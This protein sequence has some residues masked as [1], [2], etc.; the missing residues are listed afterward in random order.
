MTIVF[1]IVSDKSMDT[2]QQ[3][4]DFIEAQITDPHMYQNTALVVRNV[5]KYIV[6]NLLNP[7]DDDIDLT[8][9]YTSAQI[10]QMIA[11][12][13]LN[14]GTVV[15]AS[16]INGNIR[17]NNVEMKVFTDTH[18]LHKQVGGLGNKFLADDNN[19]YEI[20]F[21]PIDPSGHTH[22]NFSALDKITDNGNGT[23]VLTD[24]GTYVELPTSS[25]TGSNGTGSG[26]TWVI[27]PKVAITN[28]VVSVTNTAPNLP[29]ADWNGTN[30][31]YATG[32]LPFTFT[33]PATGLVRA[34]ALVATP[35]GLWEIITGEEGTT[36]ATPQLVNN[37][38]LGAYLL[39][40]EV[41]GGT[42]VYP[43]DYV[44]HT[45][46][47]TVL[48]NYQLRNVI[49]YN[50]IPDGAAITADYN[51]S[52][53][54]R[55]TVAAV[56][57]VS[58]VN[59]PDGAD[60]R[61]KFYNPNGK[62]LTL[63]GSGHTNA[64]GEAITAITLGT[65]TV[66]TFLVNNVSGSLE[67]SEIAE[68]GA[69][70][71]KYELYPFIPSFAYEAEDTFLDGDILYKFTTGHAANTYANQAAV[72]TANYYLAGNLDG[73]L[74]LINSQASLSTGTASFA[75]NSQNHR[76][77]LNP[78][79]PAGQ[80]MTISL[81]G[82]I[83]QSRRMLLEIKANGL[84]TI[85]PV[86]SRVTGDMS[87][88]EGITANQIAVYELYAYAEESFTLVRKY[89]QGQEATGGLGNNIVRSTAGDY[90][91]DDSTYAPG[92]V[93]KAHADGGTDTA[94]RYVLVFSAPETGGTSS[95]VFDSTFDNSF[96]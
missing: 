64:K 52:Q 85:D 73:A 69:T 48:E 28:M 4:K 93:L 50:T 92:Y 27:A 21:D 65:G 63:G 34:D 3:I 91:I 32:D 25:D 7:A 13:T 81:N 45:E 55:H 43:D 88:P 74:Y 6:D 90:V 44:T 9:Y 77:N 17:V 16:E 40:G 96:E 33:M 60:L 75:V 62:T 18:L 41:D 46:L 79:A 39:W 5:L 95:G 47:T 12:L 2:R 15:T 56:T 20:S 78:S 42:V 67:W 37:R 49:S 57:S 59:I 82:R 89:I 54:H 19:Y 24:K 58:A 66:S 51:V 86:A 10:D 53:N 61:I 35:T 94:K 87:L 38:L 30:I 72:P 31:N 14:G 83:P 1:P 29:I 11:D 23:R 8:G 71:Q 76:Y 26:I 22:N 80:V 36:L 68:A 70:A 84:S